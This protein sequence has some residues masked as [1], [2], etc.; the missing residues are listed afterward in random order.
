MPAQ[1]SFRWFL[2]SE[3]CT[4]EI[5]QT[6]VT[7]PCDQCL[8]N[9]GLSFV[10]SPCD[11]LVT[12]SRKQFVTHLSLLL[13]EKRWVNSPSDKHWTNCVCHWFVAP[14]RACHAFVTARPSSDKRVTNWLLGPI[15]P[16]SALSSTRTEILRGNWL[17]RSDKQWTNCSVCQSFVTFTFRFFQ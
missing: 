9:I 4:Q 2:I 6:L 7:S 12:N 16:T 15:D 17:T 13:S 5:G 11:Q 10:R 14:T 1:E 8:T 3:H